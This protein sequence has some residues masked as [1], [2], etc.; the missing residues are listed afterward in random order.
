MAGVSARLSILPSVFSPGKPALAKAPAARKVTKIDASRVEDDI[1]PADLY[2]R[3]IRAALRASNVGTL[4][5]VNK[6]WHSQVKVVLED[7]RK[8]NV[9]WWSGPGRPLSCE[10][11][12]SEL[13]Y[14]EAC[15]ADPASITQLTFDVVD[16]GH[17]NVR[18]LDHEDISTALDLDLEHISHRG[19]QKGYLTSFVIDAFASWILTLGR[20][21]ACFA[22]NPLCSPGL[23]HVYLPSS[24]FTE[25]RSADMETDSWN[26][27][28]KNIIAA[29]TI[30]TPYHKGS[31]KHWAL[32]V[33]YKKKKTVH[34]MDPLGLTGV[35]DANIVLSHLA[36]IQGVHADEFDE[37]R[38]EYKVL[39]HS[40][41]LHGLPKQTDTR[42]CGVFVSV[43][44]YHLLRR[45]T[46]S[47]GMADI[48]AWRKFM[49]AKIHA[50]HLKCGVEHGGH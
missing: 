12:E 47:F 24:Y 34:V 43:M 18:F 40:P 7:L 46:M 32:M 28:R 14:V 17:A 48:P 11:A 29:H 50:L 25:L 31:A 37:W 30:Y 3:I 20:E 5:R 1:V 49:V 42:S 13:K 10:L 2:P 27:V 19:A 35:V 22:D 41:A 15:C 26:I 6:F 23:R 33:V 9:C 38:T 39:V 36:K 4:S 44:L 8:M 45:A 16:M 21:K